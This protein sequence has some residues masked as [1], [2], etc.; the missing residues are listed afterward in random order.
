MTDR[1]NIS[2]MKANILQSKQSFMKSD[3]ASSGGKTIGSI[4]V[5]RTNFAGLWT[6][7]FNFDIKFVMQ[8]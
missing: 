6:G 1:S 2:Q 3:I 7:T 5:D 8:N 4:Q